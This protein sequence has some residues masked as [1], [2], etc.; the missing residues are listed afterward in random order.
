MDNENSK[1]T[2]KYNL[3]VSATDTDG[4]Q[5]S[6]YVIVNVN[7]IQGEI[8]NGINGDDIL[9]LRTMWWYLK[10]QLILEITCKA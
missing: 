9:K 7:D 1:N 4:N 2:N 6:Q 8:L 10:L 5:S 3:V